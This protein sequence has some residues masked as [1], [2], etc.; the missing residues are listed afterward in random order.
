M[1]IVGP[2]KYNMGAKDRKEGK[3]SK[4]WQRSQDIRNQTYNAERLAKNRRFK[5]LSF[6]PPTYWIHDVV[7]ENH[8]IKM[9]KPLMDK[10]KSETLATVGTVF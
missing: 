5:E 7:I 9:I 1:Q 6:D 8:A 2:R 10:V 4:M 3:K